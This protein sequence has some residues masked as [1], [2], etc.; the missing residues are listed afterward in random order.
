MPC[1]AQA[2]RIRSTAWK[3]VR[4]R[5][6]IAIWPPAWFA[7]YLDLAAGRGTRL[8][9]VLAPIS[10]LVVGVLFYLVLGRLS[11]DYAERLGAVMSVSAAGPLERRPRGRIWLFRSGESRAVAMDS[12]GEGK[13]L[14]EEVLRHAVAHEAYADEADA[15]VAHAVSVVSRLSWR[16]SQMPITS[17]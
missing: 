6:W 1:S 2:T 8:E 14:G 15:G 13:A 12:E 11:L 7:G 3:A 10:I 17:A 5:T 16:D 4:L 9:A